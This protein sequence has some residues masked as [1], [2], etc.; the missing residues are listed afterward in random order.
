STSSAPTA[1]WRAATGA[2]ATAAPG[3]STSCTRSGSSSGAARRRS[4]RTSSPSAGSRCRASC[5]RDRLRTLRTPGCPPARGARVPRRGVPAGSADQRRAWLPGLVAGR[6]FASLAYLEESDRHDAGG[7]TLRARRT[8]DGYAL[9]G[10]K[11]FVL[12]AP[13]ADLFLVAARTRAGAGPAGVSLFLVPRKAAGVRVR[14]E[15]T[16]DLTR[17]VGEVTLRDVAVPRGAL[18]GGEG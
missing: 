5:A 14:P 10:A 16:I 7:V 2:P 1:R 4:R 3:R 15:E 12:D 6:A 17:R 8:R 9:A 11:L 18:L 13:G